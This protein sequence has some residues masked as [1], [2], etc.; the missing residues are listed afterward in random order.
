[1]LGIS[2]GGHPLGMHREI[3]DIHNVICRGE[4]EI[5]A[6]SAACTHA[7]T[8][9]REIAIMSAVCIVEYIR[10]ILRRR[11]RLSYIYIIYFIPIVG[12][13]TKEPLRE[14]ELELELGFGV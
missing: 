7:R 14:L 12:R 4:R 5:G 8:H 13:S 2:R 9:G 10:H 6:I 1:M 3:D 11:S